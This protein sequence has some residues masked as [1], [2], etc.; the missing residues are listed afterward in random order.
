MFVDACAIIAVLSDEP[1]AE[2]ISKALV[3][4]NNSFTSPIAV[5]ETVISLART[6][7]FDRPITDVEPIVMEFLDERGITVR[8]LPPASEATRLALLA[9]HRYRAGR[10]A[11]NIGDCLHY[12]CAK[13]F[14]VPILATASEFAQT[15]IKTV[16]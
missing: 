3:S 12:A 5:L 16:P 11:L 10:H 7:K 13:Y 14:D 2:R 6:D 9:A 15:D 8:D 1:E 4:A